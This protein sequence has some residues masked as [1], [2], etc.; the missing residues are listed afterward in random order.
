[1]LH[2]DDFINISKVKR[3]EKLLSGTHE[4]VH[5]DQNP[6][7]FEFVQCFTF[8]A[9]KNYIIAKI[10]MLIHNFSFIMKKGK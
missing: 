7:L 8:I 10:F 4:C 3:N 1:M 5:M 9:F 2:S 6:F